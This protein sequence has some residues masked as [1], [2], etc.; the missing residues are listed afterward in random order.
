MT[1]SYVINSRGE[2]ELF[3]FKKVYR[4][5]RRV[6]ASKTLAQK[7]AETIKKEVYP[8]IETRKI[9]GRVKSMLHRTTPQAALKFN[10]KEGMRKLGP[11]GFPFEKYIGEILASNGFEVKFNEHIT[12]YCATYEIDFLA[13]KKKFL[14]S[15]NLNKSNSDSPLPFGLKRLDQIGSKTERRPSPFDKKG[16]PKGDSARAKRVPIWYIGECKYHR[17]RGERVDLQVSLANYARFLD[18]KKEFKD[19]NV[20]SLLATNTKFTSEAKRYCKCVEVELLGWNWPKGRGL[21][22]LI[23]SEKLYPITILPSFKGCL[24]DVFSAKK[25]MLVRDILGMSPAKIS[26]RL[27]IPKKHLHELIKEAKILLK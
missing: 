18:L 5:A 11:T 3:S 7:I 17:R 25:M 23:D 27:K 21:E 8:G 16:C 20:K 26:R 2:K 15:R 9:F 6:G 22:Y 12:G 10:L 19:S 24:V 14:S 4:S 1:N 13:K